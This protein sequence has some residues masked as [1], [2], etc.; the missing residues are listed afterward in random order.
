MLKQYPAAEYGVVSRLFLFASYCLFEILKYG[1]FGAA[2]FL[3]IL[4]PAA[5]LWIKLDLITL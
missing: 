4:T 3:E 1:A 5:F 2:A